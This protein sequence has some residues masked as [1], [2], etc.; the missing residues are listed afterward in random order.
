MNDMSFNKNM[1]INTKE[2]ISLDNEKLIIEMLQNITM[3][4]DTFKTEMKQEMTDFKTEIKQE[5]NSFRTEIKQ[6]ITDFKT[7]VNDRFDQVDQ[8]LN[9]VE[10]RLEVVE[11]KLDSL[12]E[13]FEHTV[14]IQQEAMT[15]VNEKLQ[16]HTHKIVEHDQEL[17]TMKHKQ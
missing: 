12:G 3:S 2:A 6:E 10:G 13:M 5:M 7:E 17:F 4:M 11:N 16:Y 1:I 14:G 9:K 15:K 8:R